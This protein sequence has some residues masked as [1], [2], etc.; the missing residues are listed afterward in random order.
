[1][2]YDYKRYEQ[3]IMKLLENRVLDSDGLQ[4]GENVSP[5]PEIKIM[6]D[7]FGAKE[8]EGPNGEV[9]Y[10]EDG[11]EQLESFAIFIHKD[12]GKRNFVFP[13]HDVHAFTF[14]NMIQHRPKEEVCIYAW[15]DMEQDC[16]HILPLEDRLEEDSEI[17]SEM[18]MAVLERIY[19]KHYT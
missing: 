14:G 7:G 12:S 8:T 10:D 18:I 11:N 15:N 3:I 13:E 16:W 4:L 1:M 2:E 9:I 6:F 5:I 19:D 17:T